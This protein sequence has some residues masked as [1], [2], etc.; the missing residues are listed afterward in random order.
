MKKDILLHEEKKGYREAAREKKRE[1]N[2]PHR[3]EN[4]VR[5]GIGAVR[6]RGRGGSL[7]LETGG[8]RN[9]EHLRR[10]VARGHTRGKKRKR[11]GRRLFLV[12]GGFLTLC[13]EKGGKGRGREGGI[14]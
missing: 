4:A 6:S 13:L 8:G 1:N 5:E 2:R 9:K 10:F 3:N 11:R 12:T 14:H 7:L